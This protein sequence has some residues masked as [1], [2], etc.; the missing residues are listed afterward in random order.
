MAP[1]GTAA[2]RTAVRVADEVQTPSR[3]R[4]RTR[5]RLCAAPTVTPVD[6]RVVSRPPS[7][8]TGAANVGGSRHVQLKDWVLVR[9]GSRFWR[10]AV[11]ALVCKVTQ[12]LAEQDSTVCLVLP[13]LLALRHGFGSSK[14]FLELSGVSIRDIRP[15]TRSNQAQLRATLLKAIRDSRAS[16]LNKATEIPCT[17]GA[18]ASVSC[19]LANAIA[20]AERA[21]ADHA[22]AGASGDVPSAAAGAESEAKEE[23]G[24]DAGAAHAASP[25]L[26]EEADGDLVADVEFG[27][28]WL[29]SAAQATGDE[30]AELAAELDEERQLAMPL[31]DEADSETEASEEE[32]SECEAPVSA[33]AWSP[34]T[35]ATASPARK[36]LVDVAF[37]TTPPRDTRRTARPLQRE[38]SDQKD[39]QQQ[40]V[41][42]PAALAAEKLPPAQIVAKA[43]AST[44]MDLTRAIARAFH[45]RGGATELSRQ[46]LEADLGGAFTPEELSQALHKLDQE[47]KVF[48][49]GDLV[50]L[51]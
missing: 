16:N 41:S 20:A 26:A 38:E 9:N 7:A 3:S 27:G 4:S 35:A 42:A 21:S 46:E 13:N 32:E 49:S 14:P 47:N 50:F 40:P 45:K 30:D 6:R 5:S 17:T 18:P 36:E 51:I 12:G 48:V 29:G 19:P 43:P 22:E 28:V 10:D 8:A 24:G 11:P 37:H 23:H 39:V 34:S 31:V 44:M 25:W 15:Y 33:A 2:A 1:R